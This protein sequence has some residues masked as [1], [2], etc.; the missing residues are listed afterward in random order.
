MNSFALEQLN[1]KL[2][3]IAARY[4]ELRAAKRRWDAVSQELSVEEANLFALRHAVRQEYAD[5]KALE[6]ASISMI[7]NV[8]SGRHQQLVDKEVAEFVRAKQKHDELAAKVEDLKAEQAR[9][10][11]VTRQLDAVEAEY[12]QLLRQKEAFLLAGDA[13]QSR[14]VK[15][16]LND[17][18][19]DL[20]TLKHIEAAQF[21]APTILK[22]LDRVEAALLSRPRPTF[23]SRQNEGRSAAE[24]AERKARQLAVSLRPDMRQFIAELHD[25]EITNRM[26]IESGQHKTLGELF[27]DRLVADAFIYTHLGSNIEAVAETRGKVEQMSAILEA[28]HVLLTAEVT[29]AKQKREALLLA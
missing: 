28:E 10:T 24:I 4:H 20:E 5:V 15:A 23:G 21:L 25:V 14:V 2:G 6:D 17:L 1:R 22:M 18:T 12:E 29:E 7:F 11:D 19:R 3:K 9:L 13:E 8:L 27:E 26:T 16:L